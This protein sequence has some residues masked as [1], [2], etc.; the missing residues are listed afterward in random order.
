MLLNLQK[1]FVPFMEGMLCESTV[2][3]WLVWCQAEISTLKTEMAQAN[4]QVVNND[5]IK[6]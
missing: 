4:F 2:Q 1:R 3:K 5:E 6:F